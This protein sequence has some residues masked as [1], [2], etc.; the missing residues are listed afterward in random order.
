MRE[1]ANLSVLGFHNTVYYVT[2]PPVVPPNVRDEMISRF[3]GYLCN[4]LSQLMQPPI[5]RKA[6]RS[7]QS[8]SGVSVASSVTPEGKNRDVFANN[9]GNNGGNNNGGSSNNSSEGD[10]SWPQ[11][12]TLQ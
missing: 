5:W 2:L 11:L 1:D 4:Q 8:S 10:Y 3:Q 6:H 7:T 12:E 9:G